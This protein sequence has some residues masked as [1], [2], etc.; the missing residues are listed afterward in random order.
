MSTFPCYSKMR[1][2]PYTVTTGHVVSCA[3]FNYGPIV[4]K[5]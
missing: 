2:G 5:S 1:M 4:G 3:A